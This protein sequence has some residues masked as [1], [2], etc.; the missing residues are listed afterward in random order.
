VALCA[1]LAKPEHARLALDASY[2]ILKVVKFGAIY[3]GARAKGLLEQIMS[4][5]ESVLIAHTRA[6]HFTRWGPAM[7]CFGLFVSQG[8]FRHI[9]RWAPWR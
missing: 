9:G 5:R 8:I 1:R 4:A 7:N 3:F 2:I 6:G